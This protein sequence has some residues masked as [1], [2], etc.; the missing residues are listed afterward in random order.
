MVPEPAPE[1]GAGGDVSRQRVPHAPQT[2]RTSGVVPLSNQDPPHHHY[3]IARTCT[4]LGSG[5]VSSVSFSKGF[6]LSQGCDLGSVGS[7]GVLASMNVKGNNLLIIMFLILLIF[8]LLFLFLFLLLL[9]FV[10]LF[11]V[12]SL[13][14]LSLV[15]SF[16]S[17]FFSLD[18][19]FSSSKL[20]L[21]FVFLSISLL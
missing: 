16:D 6:D 14:P 9:S 8:C 17:G 13:F 19:S 11:P 21:P 4:S 12:L 15:F 10:L 7:S 2:V 18:M 20:C 5:F 1:G 3:T